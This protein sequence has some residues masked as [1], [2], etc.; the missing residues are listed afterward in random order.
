M[1]VIYKKRVYHLQWPKKFDEIILKA[2][3]KY[4]SPNGKINWKKAEADRA[5]KGLPL[6]LTLRNISQRYSHLKS[7]KTKKHQRRNSATKKSSKGGTFD[8]KKYD[9][10]K[11]IIPHDIKK[12]H[13]WKSKSIWTKEQKQILIQLT[14]MYRKSKLTIDWETLIFDPKIKKLP[15]QNKYKLMKYYGQCLKRK[16]TKEE[17]KHKQE[18][19]LRYK[20]ENYKNYRAGQRK[21]YKTVKNSINEFL[22]SQIQLR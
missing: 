10:F 20:K 4:Q 16:R 6:F 11:E 2:A 19:A 15:Y 9:L 7:T 13:G 3:K 12:K 18:G 1:K 5:L 21:R 17:I 8:K 14:K 22:L